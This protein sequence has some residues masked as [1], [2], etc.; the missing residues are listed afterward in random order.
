MR[1][2]GRIKHRGE[3]EVWPEHQTGSLCTMAS[4]SCL[5][6]SKKDY[7]HHLKQAQKCHKA[8]HVT[9]ICSSCSP[10]V[11]ITFKASSTRWYYS[12]LTLSS[13]HLLKS[14]Q[15]TRFE[16]KGGKGRTGNMS[17]L[18][19]CVIGHRWDFQKPSALRRYLY[20]QKKNNFKQ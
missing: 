5:N 15:V 2:T 14:D 10:S 11:V 12:S 17:L 20:A 18:N 16:R 3:A 4:K 6:K 7:S 19:L 9:P 1:W 13:E 8:R